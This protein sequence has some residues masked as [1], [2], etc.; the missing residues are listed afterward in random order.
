MKFKQSAKQN[1]RIERI[2][3]HHLIIGID[4]AK[5]THVARATD[6]R[7]I[8]RGT[9]LTFSNDLEGY[10]RLYQWM[11][12]LMAQFNKTDVIFGVEP[13]GHY[14]FNL[15]L[16]LQEKPLEL[17]LV[18][19]LHVKRNKENRDNSPTK[20]D[21]K[22]AL[23]I[24]DM[25]K[26]GYYSDVYLHAE[27]YR[28]LRQI[29]TTRDFITKQVSSVVN[30]IYRWTDIYF[31]EFQ[32]VF[33]DITSKTALATLAEFAH[34]SDL[35]HLAVQDVIAGWKK[36]LKR[37]GSRKAAVAL[38][39][40]AQQTVGTPDLVEEAKISLSLLLQ[41]L[42]M[43][44][45]QLDQLKEKISQ[46]LQCIPT[47]K[48]LRTVK[49]INDITLA[50]LYSEAGDLSRFSHGNQLLRLAGLHLSENSSGTYK[51]EAKITKRGRPRLRKLLFMTVLHMVSVHP[52]FRALHQYNKQIKKM[53]GMKSIMKLCGKLARI[54]VAMARTD[55]DYD[56]N[57]VR[58][59][60]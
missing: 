41:Q 10:A 26:N 46:L 8:E 53:N 44:N 39:H 21:V 45:D 29:V 13:T 49:G 18:N 24:A 35:R 34:P 4:I 6:Y 37:A 43:Y 16:W 47:V 38:I 32:Q 54:L 56:E 30:Q 1:Q 11:Q 17:V 59:A 58:V 50:A 60:A 3:S 28:A 7:G 40:A 14:W 9:Y 2:T 55:S 23:V 42:Q 33:K 12:D 5:F 57:K 31:P 48:I 36:R 19:P 25:V 51:G 15:A 27:P 52:E 20:N 22:D